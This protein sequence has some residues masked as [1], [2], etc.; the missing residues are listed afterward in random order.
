M[1]DAVISLSQSAEFLK[2]NLSVACTDPESFV[3]GGPTL[4]GFFLFCFFVC[5]FFC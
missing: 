5:V 2:W 3:R 1:S 4:T